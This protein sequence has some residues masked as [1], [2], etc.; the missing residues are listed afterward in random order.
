MEDVYSNCAIT[1]SD[2]SRNSKDVMNNLEIAFDMMLEAQERIAIDILKESYSNAE[3]ASEQAKELA[4]DITKEMKYIEGILKEKVTEKGEAIKL[5]ELLQKRQKEIQTI[6][7]DQSE[8]EAII[9]NLS[10]EF[11]SACESVVTL[12]SQKA[13][14]N[15][16]QRFL[17]F[18]FGQGFRGPTDADI[19]QAEIMRLKKYLELEGTKAGLELGHKVSEL[20]IQIVNDEAEKDAAIQAVAVE[21][22]DDVHK[23]LAEV[24][25][26]LVQAAS[27]WKQISVHCKHI[28]NDK[29]QDMIE[30]LIGNK[31]EEERR[32]LWRNPKIQKKAIQYYAKWHALYDVSCE[33]GQ[34]ICAAQTGVW[35]SLRE[36]PNQKQGLINAQE[37][38]K[39]LQETQVPS[40]K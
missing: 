29:N 38:A 28:A 14:L 37:L 9:Q 40:R 12:E 22:L 25:V 34:K 2:F 31:S 19:E 26:T 18:F 24:V 23:G 21:C 6:E 1:V 7:V 15:F 16:G 4:N 32:E 35:N 3:E 13:N 20:L 5:Q 10:N 30:R 27:F 33:F 11:E 8:D 39:Q 36:A 17:N